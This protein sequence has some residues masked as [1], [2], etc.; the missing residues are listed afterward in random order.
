MRIRLSLLAFLLLAAFAA[1][2]AASN[3]LD[4]IRVAP[5]IYELAFENE[6]VRVL[7]KTI[8]NGE[9][10]SVHSHP[11]RVIV[12]LNP[13]AWLVEKDDGSESM[14]SYKFGTPVWA[15]AESHGGRTASVIQQCSVLEIELK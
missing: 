4:P 2:Y 11:D 5:H 6:R 8:R 9:T 14:E 1:G 12:Y 15:P 7:K 13:C 3:P 10:P